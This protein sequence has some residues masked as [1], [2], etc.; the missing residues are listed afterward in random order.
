MTLPR[1]VVPGRFYLVTRRCT[2]RQFL[3]RP[4]AS[5]NNA[6][7]YCLGEAAQ[8]FGIDVLLV[9]AMSNHYHAVVYDRD[10]VLPRFTEHF[11][12]M[13]AKT[14]NAARGR[15]ENFW[16]SEQVCVVRLAERTDVLNK[17]AYVAANPVKDHLVERAHQWPG[18]NGFKALLSGRPLRARRPAHFFRPDGSMPASVTLD[19]VVPP[20]LGARTAL[21]AELRTLV[22]NRQDDAAQER[23]RAGRQVLGCRAVKAQ[24]WRAAPTTRA[25]R[26][27]L[28]PQLAARSAWAREEAVLRNRAFVDA[29]RAARERWVAGGRAIFPPGT[30]WLRCF[31]NV[32][33]A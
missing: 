14:L 28:R 18:V 1:E 3:L 8:R 9:T 4:D 12:K 5:T 10:G 11:H 33:I 22:G 15:W 32:P 16:S 17:L 13:L 31:A 19:L 23:R 29:Y 27:S 30:Y 20:E 26:R 21:V 24:S 2:Q 7:I 6:F 25:R